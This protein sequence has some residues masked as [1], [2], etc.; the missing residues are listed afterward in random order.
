ML[1]DPLSSI[2]DFV[3]STADKNP[4]KAYHKVAVADVTDLVKDPM[5][6]PLNHVSVSIEQDCMYC[7]W[8]DKKDIPQ[9]SEVQTIKLV[10][11]KGLKH[12]PDSG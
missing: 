3:S 5:S 1:G 12:N 4:I 9:D 10:T 6:K 7:Y 11:V 8:F 2:L